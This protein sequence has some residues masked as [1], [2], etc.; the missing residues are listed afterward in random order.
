LR[1]RPPEGVDRLP[2][3]GPEGPAD[4]VQAGSLHDVRRPDARHPQ[5]GQLADVPRD[6]R[7]AAP[8]AP[9]DAAAAR[10]DAERPERRAADLARTR[11]AGR[12]HGGT[13]GRDR[14]GDGRCTPR[15]SG[16]RSGRRS[17]EHTS[18]LQSRENL[19]CR[20]L[21]EKKNKWKPSVHIYAASTAPRLP[22][23]TTLR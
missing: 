4:R 21:L 11:A 13:A 16:R 1:P 9:S 12:A 14:S 10:A 19:V 15:G 20:L 5:A 7:G 18:E 6:A 22:S 17:E 2:R 8:A 3:L 23:T